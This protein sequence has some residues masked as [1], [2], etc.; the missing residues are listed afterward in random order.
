MIFI[1]AMTYLFLVWLIYFRLKVLPFNLTNKIGVATLGMI[2]IVGLMLATNYC[3]PHTS[4]VRVYQY[5]IPIAPNLPKPALVTE[6]LVQPNVAIKKGAVLF[7]LDA[8]PFQYEVT[9]LEAALAAA[10]T[11]QPKLE[12]NLKAAQAALTS[13]EA[14][15][16]NTRSEFARQEKLLPSGATSRE[17]FQ[18]AETAARN[19]EAVRRQASAELERAKMALESK[20]GGEFTSVAQVKQ[21]LASARL[22]LENT[23][24]RAPED[25][26]VTQLSLRPGLMV[27]SATPVMSFVSTSQ[28]PVVVATYTQ[29]P[30]QHIE[31][32]ASVEIVF[33]MFP[34]RV[35]KAQVE[36]VIAITGQGQIAING[37]LLEA[38]QPQQR[39]R[40]AVRLKLKEEDLKLL[41]GGAGGSAVV[42]TNTL[43]ALGIIQK[44]SIRME[45]YANYITPF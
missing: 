2:V 28:L 38:T 45:G 5:V 13:S 1:I 42:Y 24:V 31:P 39:G 14:T 21:Q 37:G 11:D 41:P 23:T 4:D 3:H 7:Q 43:R 29:N 32:G 12:A 25:G 40:F 36:T 34:G 22:H 26:F 33:T 27:S 16:E 19:A 15:L 18:N 44:M 9:R 8:R 10:H 20:I 17:N 30:L 35:F 6:V